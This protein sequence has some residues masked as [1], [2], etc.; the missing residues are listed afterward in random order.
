MWKTLE[1]RVADQEPIQQPDMGAVPLSK[2]EW[3][4]MIEAA[5]NDGSIVQGAKD[6]VNQNNGAHSVPD[7]TD[8]QNSGDHGSR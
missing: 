2:E 7:G 6:Q 5:K 3:K 8:S 1:D 4:S